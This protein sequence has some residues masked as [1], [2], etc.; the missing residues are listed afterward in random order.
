MKLV[1]DLEYVAKTRRQ[2][3]LS[4]KQR[5][6]LCENLYYNQEFESHYK[7]CRQNRNKQILALRATDQILQQVKIFE[8]LRKNLKIT[9]KVPH[10]SRSMPKKASVLRHQASFN[11]SPHMRPTP[12]TPNNSRKIMRKNSYENIVNRNPEL[13]SLV[14][15][16]TAQFKSFTEQLY[17][18]S[19]IF[20]KYLNHLTM[21][22]MR[23]TNDGIVRA[24]IREVLTLAPEEQ[25]G[26]IVSCLQTLMTFIE[27]RLVLVN[28]INIKSKLQ[29]NDF[30]TNCLQQKAQ[31]WMKK[32]LNYIGCVVQSF[33]NSPVDVEIVRAASH[34]EIKDSSCSSESSQDLDNIKISRRSSLINH[35]QEK[36]LNSNSIQLGDV[37]PLHRPKHLTDDKTQYSS[38]L[39][40]IPDMRDNGQRPGDVTPSAFNKNNH[41][42]NNLHFMDKAFDESNSMGIS[43]IDILKS[44]AVNSGQQELNLPEDTDPEVT[45]IKSEQVDTDDDRAFLQMRTEVTV[46]PQSRFSKYCKENTRCSETKT[47]VFETEIIELRFNDEFEKLT[48]SDPGVYY[49]GIESLEKKLSRVT[50]SDFDYMKTLG[51]GAFGVVYLVRRKSTH[52]IFALKVVNCGRM[53]QAEL[54][55]LLNETQ[56]LSLAQGEFVLQAVSS[57]IHKQLMCFVMEFMPGG[58]LRKLLDNEG[59]FDEE[60]TRFYLAQIVAGLES[61]H[62]KGIYHRDLKPENIL[63]SANGHVKLADFGLSEI[64]HEVV[65]SLMIEKFVKFHFGLNIDDCNND[66]LK[67]QIVPKNIDSGLIR[68]V[69]TPDYIAPEVLRGD[70]SGP[71]SDYWAVGVMAYE[72]LTNF[73][74]FNDKTIDGVFQNIKNMRLEWLRTGPDGISPEMN[75]LIRSLLQPDVSKRLGSKGISEIKSHPFFSSINWKTLPEQIPP[76]IPKPFDFTKIQADQIVDMAG[77]IE[78]AFPEEQRSSN[79]KLPKGFQV[80]SQFEFMRYDVLH[81][82]NKKAAQSIR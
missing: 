72:F 25:V 78:K 71:V 59:Y 54:E 41:T 48:V 73:P 15:L 8:I 66:L 11:S 3:L 26:K 58:D 12:A 61:L 2:M 50:L 34:E 74:P 82:L 31:I 19:H 56:V 17:M 80:G 37:S 5:C 57:F 51:K 76:Y 32:K 63:I 42:F 46:H 13:E 14:K 49:R 44:P 53:S 6:R 69:G 28:E 27:T 55:S 36:K 64:K 47:E 81:S 30:N 35:G 65:M 1:H 20:D 24:K 16:S 23:A 67:A 18:L 4:D 45:T 79:R 75:D 52:D 33:F 9:I 21:D 22:S 60:W 70:Q 7:I 10:S 40:H 43:P 77:F 62:S 38:S 39:R 29:K 68:I